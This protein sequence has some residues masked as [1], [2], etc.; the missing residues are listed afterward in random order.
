MIAVLEPDK[1]ADKG[2]MLGI[3]AVPELV[4]RNRITDDA[5]PQ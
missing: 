4:P 2:H 3:R 5:D 1:I